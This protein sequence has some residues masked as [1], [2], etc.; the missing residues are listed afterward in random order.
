MRWNRGRLAC[1]AWRTSGDNRLVHHLPGARMH[2]KHHGQTMRPV[3]FEERTEDGVQA[4]PDVR[5]VVPVYGGQHEFLRPPAPSAS[6]V[7]ERSPPL[8]RSG[9]LLSYI[10]SPHCSHVG[11]VQVGG[12]DSCRIEALALKVVHSGVGRAEQPGAAVI[13]NDPVQLLGHALIE[14]TQTRLDMGHRDV[15]L[16]RPPRHRPACCWY[17]RRA[18]PRRAALRSSTFSMP[19]IIRAVMA[20]CAPLP[21]PKLMSAAGMPSSSKNTW[22]M[23]AS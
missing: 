12:W 23:L 1:N 10:T 15:Q 7:V 13:A 16:A 18:P 5:V 8:P 14:G 3:Q 9:V 6:A 2:G 21:T 22:L 4:L 17:R 19:S 20:P 11:M